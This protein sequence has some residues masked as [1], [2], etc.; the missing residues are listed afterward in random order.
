MKN[1][2]YI[3]DNTSETDYSNID[4]DNIVLLVDNS[5]SI[6]D[7][8][9]VSLD[10]KVDKVT[11]SSLIADTSITRLAN[12]SGENTGDQ[13]LSGKLD[14]NTTI[15]PSTKTKI[16]YDADGLVT[17][18]DDATTEDINDSTD[19]RYLTDTQKTEATR[20]ATTSQNGLIS[21]TDWNTFNDKQDSGNYEPAFTKNTAFNK[22]FGTT[23][24]TIP[25]GN[26]VLRTSD[27]LTTVTENNKLITVEDYGGLIYISQWNA[28]TNTPTLSDSDA[29]KF[30][31]A[32]IS[33]NAFTRFGIDWEKGDYLV[34]DI[35]GDIFREENP[36]KNIVSTV[37]FSNDYD[38][39]DNLPTIKRTKK[40]ISTAT[41]TFEASDANKYIEF[42][43]ECVATVPD[44][45]PADLEF[46]GEQVGTGALT[47]EATTTL[48]VFSG[49]LK[50][51]AGQH[52]VFG[53]RTKGSNIATLIGTLKLA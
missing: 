6:S 36:L 38:D 13:D 31:D 1:K 11:G 35:N 45:L 24:G 18:G 40:P 39:L 27:A 53:I 28:E 50:E 21:P 33:L 52:A 49:F 32:Y 16:T 47:F 10:G 2:V 25:Q 29:T 15:T 7:D 44:G 51:T 30:R 20:N 9:Q 46:Q 3:L 14:K 43:N 5:I 37:G 34:Y 22:N 23:S 17:E 19:R 26:E 12:T 48:N 41:Y 4:A 42:S 8:T